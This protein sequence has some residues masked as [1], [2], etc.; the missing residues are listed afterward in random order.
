M[1][2]SF[3]GMS[4]EQLIA[5]VQVLE[6]ENH[7]CWALAHMGC[8]DHYE[9]A[10]AWGLV[11]PYDIVDQD[12]PW[13]ENWAKIQRAL[14]DNEVDDLEML[15]SELQDWVTPNADWF[16][17]KLPPALAETYERL[18]NGIEDGF[19]A[20]ERAFTA[21]L[22]WRKEQLKRSGPKNPRIQ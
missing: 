6:Y 1:R 14:R 18:Y 5:R 10:E 11:N 16:R 12:R 17:P 21:L 7:W 4:R 3:E 19:E 15:M 2:E 9:R 13:T 20:R 22:G 8:G